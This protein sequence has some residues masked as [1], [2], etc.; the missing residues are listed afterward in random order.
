MKLFKCN[1]VAQ[2][3]IGIWLTEQGIEPED[4][5]SAELLGLNVV[6]ITNPAGQ[7]MI[8]RWVDGHAEIDQ[9]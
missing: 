4:I 8:I 7:Y 9:S 2:F 6:K 5:A 3:K 1:T